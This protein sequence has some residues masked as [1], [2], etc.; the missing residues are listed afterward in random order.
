LLNLCNPHV[1]SLL[2]KADS[3]S[4]LVLKQ[5]WISRLKINELLSSVQFINFTCDLWTSPNAKAILVITAHWIDNEFDLKEILLDAVEVE[6]A[7]SGVNIASY[8]LTA[9]EEFSLNDKLF[10]ITGDNASNNRTMTQEIERH[11]SSFKVDG[12]LLGCTGHVFNLAAV[13]GLK[14]IG[15]AVRDNLVTI[16]ES[17]ERD[18]EVDFNWGEEGEDEP[19]DENFDPASII[20]RVREFCKFVRCSPQRRNLFEDCVKA[21]YSSLPFHS[22]NPAPIASTS[23]P[24]QGQTSTHGKRPAGDLL[25]NTNSDK[26]ARKSAKYKMYKVLYL[27]ICLSFRDIF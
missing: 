6:G 5:F 1:D 2:V 12:N 23:Q 26:P 25:I 22:L 10:C 9:L 4:D 21:C 24:D 7:H 19:S 3:L 11:I 16:E 20:D 8:L 17:E 18:T 27:R 13:A 15:Y 14:V